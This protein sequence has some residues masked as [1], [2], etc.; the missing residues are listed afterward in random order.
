MIRFRSKVKRW[1][2]MKDDTI[3]IPNI[4]LG[5]FLKIL[6]I[7]GGFAALIYG[8][9]SD[10]DVVKAKLESQQAMLAA[11]NKD[12]GSVKY[13]ISKLRDDILELYRA[14]NPRAPG[15]AANYSDSNKL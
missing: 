14:G 1:W 7:V 2:A 8:M 10:L 12:V 5:N 4:S 6:A 15:I 11:T 9:R 13:Q 3:K